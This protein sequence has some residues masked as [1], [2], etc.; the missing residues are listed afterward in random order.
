MPRLEEWPCNQGSLCQNIVYQWQNELQCA[1]P[2]HKATY[3]LDK[4]CSRSIDMVV[5]RTFR[6]CREG[7]ILVSPTT[8]API[9][10]YQKGSM[11]SH[12]GTLAK[13]PCKHA[14][15]SPNVSANLLLNSKKHQTIPAGKRPRSSH[16]LW[17]TSR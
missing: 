5:G 15:A 8:L 1:G 13:P 16:K 12:A 14:L 6:S 4:P 11:V 2:K 3:N 17:G 7:T 10:S 9:C